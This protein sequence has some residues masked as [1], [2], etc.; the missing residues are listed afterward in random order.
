MIN[1]QDN[2]MDAAASRED[3]LPTYSTEFPKGYGDF[4]FKSSEGVIFHFPRFLLSHASPIFN[5]MYEMAADNEDEMLTLTEDYEILEYLL[6]HIDP[7]KDRPN[8]E[9]VIV[10]DVLAAADKYQIKNVFSWFEKEVTIEVLNNNPPTMKEPLLCL[11]LASRY[12][13]RTIARMALRQLVKCPMKEITRDVDIGEPLLKRL[14]TLRAARIQWLTDAIVSL[15]DS[16]ADQPHCKRHSIPFIT[17]AGPALRAI[18]LEPSWR[19]IF[20]TTRVYHPRCTCRGPSISVEWKERALAIE[21][22]L[23]ALE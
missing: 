15:G 9:W 20:T 3:L 16:Y 14:F 6:R 18:V 13:L 4:V 8:L 17:W 10:A 21:N 23:P 22:E 7:A 19:V 1:N 5:A 11:G 2:D 12:G